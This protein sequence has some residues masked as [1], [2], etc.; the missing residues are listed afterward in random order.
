MSRISGLQHE[1]LR[2][3]QGQSSLAGSSHS[4]PS[5]LSIAFLSLC[6]CSLGGALP[7]RRSRASHTCFSHA[8]FQSLQ[9]SL[10]PFA[11][12]VAFFWSGDWQTSAVWST[13]FTAS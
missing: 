6:L 1:P 4:P 7:Q 3:A 2:S 9:V 11:L 10:M 12:R 5:M 13:A 8:F